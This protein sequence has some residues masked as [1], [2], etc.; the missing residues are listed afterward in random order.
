[1]NTSEKINELAIS[2]AKFQAKI[3]RVK[4]DAW[5]PIHGSKYADL[6][7]IMDVVQPE[8]GNEGLSFCSLICEPERNEKGV[9]VSVTGLLMHNSGQWIES[10]TSLFAP[11]QTS[12]KS[13]ELITGDAQMIGSMVTY[14]RR[15][16]MSAV[17]GIAAGDDDGNS[18]SVS[19]PEPEPQPEPQPKKKS[20]IQEILGSQLGQSEK[21]SAIMQL[22]EETP[23]NALF[24]FRNYVED[25]ATKGKIAFSEEFRNYLEVQANIR[26]KGPQ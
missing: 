3:N 6:A 23:D 8:L 2:L 22:L 7:S 15:Y 11:Y 17:L 14:L 18:V 26:K 4:K 10:T 5:N 9:K 20:K 19:E 24:A 16:I 25:S 13:G 1:M 12:K 21:E